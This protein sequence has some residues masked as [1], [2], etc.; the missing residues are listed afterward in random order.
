MSS[1]NCKEDYTISIEKAN[2][3]SM[4]FIL[5]VLFLFGT[6]FLIRWGWQGVKTGFLNLAKYPMSGLIYFISLFLGIVVHELI[7]GFVWALK[8]EK[9]W[10]SIE[11]GI[12]WKMLTPYTHCKVPLTVKDYSQGVVM[13]G[14]IIGI[15]PAI[16]AI[17]N[18]SLLLWIFGL[19]FTIA[20]G[21]DFIALIMLSKLDNDQLIQDHPEQMGFII[22][23]K[24]GK[25]E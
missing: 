11:F 7:H 9:G 16:I 2:L 13:P 25:S 21:G 15:I 24:K 4:V 3:Y 17:I 10:Q 8:A 1:E 20:A 14:L 6:P 5:P 19:L 18:G 12:K 23:N 22:F